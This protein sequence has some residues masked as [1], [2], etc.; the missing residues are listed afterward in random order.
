MPIQTLQDTLL[1][2]LTENESSEL[3]RLLRKFVSLTTNA[4]GRRCASAGLDRRRA[5]APYS[6]LTPCSRTVETKASCCA[7]K[8]SANFAG[9]MP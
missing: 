9:L 3:L 5:N 1:E 6:K 8:N 2:G 7:R 4:A